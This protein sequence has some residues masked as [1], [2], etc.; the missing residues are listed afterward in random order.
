MRKFFRIMSIAGFAAATAAFSLIVLGYFRIPNEFFV[1]GNDSVSIGNLYSVEYEAEKTRSVLGSEYNAEIKLLNAIPVKNSKVTVVNRRYVV[2]GGNVFGMRIYSD[3][4]LIVGADSITTENGNI[5]PAE[6]AG[7]KQG[8]VITQINGKR[9]TRNLQAALMFENCGGKPLKLT[10]KRKGET[11][12]VDF[13]PALSA[14]EGKYR[15][16][17]W[18]RDSSAGVG[19]V[20][21]YDRNTGMF[22][23]LGH[24]ICD[25]DTGEIMPLLSGDTV[26]TEIRGCYKGSN[27]TP[28]ELC[29]VFGTGT[30]GRL[31]SNNVT[32]V[33]GV[34]DSPDP[35]AKLIPVAMKQEVKTGKAQII[36]TITD[37][38]PT[39]YDV[40]ITK[41]YAGTDS[42]QKNLVIKVT[43]DRLIEQTGGIVQGMS[44]SPIIQNGML[45]GAVTHV[46]VNDPLQGYGIFAQTMLESVKEI[47][48]SSVA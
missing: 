41:V 38:K 17:L 19:V 11:K 23:G 26:E 34:F 47:E 44:G 36:T 20:T 13:T 40:E 25:A 6:K 42:V 31:L 27:G 39:L 14:A 30:T 10:V 37:N 15:A 33:Y 32:G 3:G 7:L 12:T 28:G 1:T 5:N 2:P 45:V 48:K 4:V 29:G 24:A 43:D 35:D 9:I 18:I 46:F 8:D 21:F 16:G 22:G